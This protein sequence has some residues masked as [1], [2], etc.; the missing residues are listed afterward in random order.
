MKP[1][2]RSHEGWT[3][4]EFLR[5]GPGLVALPYLQSPPPGF[6]YAASGEGWLAVAAYEGGIYN[7]F[8]VA[9]D[10]NLDQLILDGA[11]GSIYQ[12]PADRITGELH[13]KTRVASLSEPKS[14]AIRTRSGGSAT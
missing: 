13:C 14:I 6:A 1:D 10:G 7:V 4:R 12:L 3:G 11:T 8:S 9:E 2:G 5:G